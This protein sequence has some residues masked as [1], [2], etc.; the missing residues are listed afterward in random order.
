MKA[1]KNTRSGRKGASLARSSSLR[2][3][4]R[5]MRI[6]LDPGG[7]P[8]DRRQTHSTLLK[9]LREEAG[10]VARAVRRK[11]WHNLREELGDV[12]LQVVFHSE[13]ARR[14][15]RFSLSDVIRTVNAK[16]VRRHPH[17]FGGGKLL[18]TPA[19]VLRQWKKIKKAEK[20]KAARR[21]SGA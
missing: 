19:Q 9:Y 10:E 5:V 20:E 18:G 17:V 2:S 13:L 14:A 12:L 11:D 4:E 7:C 3:L 1:A 6:L 21:G 8:W 16:M 15:G